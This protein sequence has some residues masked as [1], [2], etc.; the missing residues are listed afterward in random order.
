MT[1]KGY[2][3]ALI[4]F[5]AVTAVSCGRPSPTRANSDSTNTVDEK[6]EKDT[7]IKADTTTSKSPTAAQLIVPGKSVGQTTINE[8]A[9]SVHK[10]L[11]NADDG[12]A[13]MGKSMSIWYANHDTVGYKTQIYFSRNMGND[14][15]SRVKQIRVT[16]PWFK[17]SDA[18]HAGAPLKNAA[19]AFKLT[20]SG[21]FT[22]KGNTYTI[23]DDTTSGIAF[24][25]NNHDICTGI[26]VYEPGKAAGATYL[27]FYP[28]F[29]PVK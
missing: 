8:A 1:I 21:T 5:A 2:T 18:I 24:E 13:A 3:Y 23:Y 25:A 10:K 27:P 29:K 6:V 22:E 17:V 19:Q 9:E 15:T 12:D 11:G 14:E 28:D 26:V 4:L 20:P 16:S 7:V